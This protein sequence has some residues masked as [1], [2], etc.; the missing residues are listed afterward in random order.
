MVL[1]CGVRLLEV[2]TFTFT[3]G[4]FINIPLRTIIERRLYVNLTVLCDFIELLCAA[5]VIHN[6]YEHRRTLH[7]VVLP[8]SLIAKTL[9]VRIWE[10]ESKRHVP[11]SVY[12]DSVIS[13]LEPLF[14][15]ANRG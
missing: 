12:T 2:G 10:Q 14:A 15:G 5:L 8:R 11:F 4:V 9:Q 6:A 1:V 7:G 3:F 13:L